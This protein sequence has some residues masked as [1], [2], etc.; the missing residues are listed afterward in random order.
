MGP[1]AGTQRRAARLVR[2]RQ[3]RFAEFA[4]RYRAELTAQRP[5]LTE[6]RRRARTGTVTLLFAARDANHS[7]NAV[8]SDTLRRGLR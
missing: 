1:R 8:L 7:N 2:L 3:E 6:L 5:H 4:R